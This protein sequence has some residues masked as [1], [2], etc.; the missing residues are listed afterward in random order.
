MSNEVRQEA[1]ARPAERASKRRQN[2][3]SSEEMLLMLGQPD[4]PALLSDINRHTKAASDVEAYR[5]AL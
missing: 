1:C 5:R 3:P 2:A 4:F